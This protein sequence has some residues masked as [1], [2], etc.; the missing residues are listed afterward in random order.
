MM[1]TEELGVSMKPV[2]MT[3]WMVEKKLNGP[4]WS[5]TSFTI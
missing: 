5:G 2:M 1:P 3:D 4:D